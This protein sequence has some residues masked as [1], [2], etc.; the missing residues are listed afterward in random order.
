MFEV[1]EQGEQFV[2]KNVV[3]KQYKKIVIFQM[4][5][6]F[7]YFYLCNYCDGRAIVEKCLKEFKVGSEDWFNF[8]DYYF[9][10]IM[11]VNN[12]LQSVVIFKLVYNNFKFCKQDNEIVEK[13]DIY[14]GYIEYLIQVE[15]KENFVF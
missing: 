4:K 6:M 7:V 14:E 3:Y 11:Y 15:G 8:M 10:L 1:C 13:W 2:Q 9:L 12:F 5:K